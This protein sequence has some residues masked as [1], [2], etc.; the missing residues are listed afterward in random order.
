VALGVQGEQLLHL[1]HTSYATAHES[2]A[3]IACRV[4]C[5]SVGH[6]SVTAEAA[7]AGFLPPSPVATSHCLL[8]RPTDASLDRIIGLLTSCFIQNTITLSS[9]S[10]LSHFVTLRAEKE[11][12]YYTVYIHNAL[13]R[14]CMLNNCL[15]W[16]K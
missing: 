10:S 16:D 14:L 8:A 7:A 15:E 2:G 4:V 9:L 6:K 3:A 13:Q 12:I 1:L 5:V 11:R